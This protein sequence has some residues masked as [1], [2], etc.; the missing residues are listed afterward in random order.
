MSQPELTINIRGKLIDFHIPKVMA[1]INSTPDS[2]YA[3]SRGDSLEK[4]Y[5]LID[6]AVKEGA[7]ILDIGG[8]STRPG[9]ESC[10]AGEEY[11]RIKPALDYIKEFYPELPLSLDTWRSEVARKAIETWD[12]DIINDISGGEMDP[13]LWDVVAES[14][15]IYVLTHTR[16]TPANMHTL[17]G[18]DD[19]TAEVIKE[20][21]EKL[22]VLRGKKINDIIIDPGFGFAKTSSQNLRL[23]D[24]LEQFC[25]I[26][27]PVLV[28]LSRKSMIWKTLDTTPEESFAGTVALDALALEKGADILRVHDVKAAKETV[29]LMTEMKKR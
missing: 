3:E 22:F 2:F 18:Y 27:F 20:L 19:V 23:L 10:S 6:R 25:H 9:S 15:K 17:T 5:R 28:G 16:G 29:R 8:C 14:K 13:D 26:G 21:S 12:V 7:D 1:I 11:E 24:D 4:L